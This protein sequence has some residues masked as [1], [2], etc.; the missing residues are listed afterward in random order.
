MRCGP[1]LRPWQTLSSSLL[2]QAAPYSF[3]SIKKGKVKEKEGEGEDKTRG[4]WEIWKQQGKKK[5]K[6]KVLVKFLNLAESFISVFVPTMQC[7]W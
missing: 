3:A 4:R 5:R 7:N 6:V 1:K 2:R